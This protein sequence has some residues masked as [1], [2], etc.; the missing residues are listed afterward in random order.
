MGKLKSGGVDPH[1]IM[2]EITESTA[3]ADPDRTQRIL[4]E[5]HAW[6][7][8]LALDDLGTGYSSLSRLKHLPVD[9]LKI[10]RSFVPVST[11]TP[12]TRTWSER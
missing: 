3:M 1:T 4:T 9:I 8:S 11:P 2:V 12:T 10:D 7:L 5:M 6:G